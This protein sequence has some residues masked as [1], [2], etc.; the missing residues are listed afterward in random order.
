MINGGKVPGGNWRRIVWETAATCAFAVGSRLAVGCRKILTIASPL[1]VVDS[2]VLDG[3]IDSCCQDSL[4]N[5][6]Q[7]PFDLLRIQAGVL[8]RHRNN[9]NIDVGKMSVG[10]RRI[11][12]GLRITINRARTM[13]V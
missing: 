10:V 6:S 9:R 11:T 4:I 13:N 1:T 12:T 8:P 3:I 7:P 2:N 5:T